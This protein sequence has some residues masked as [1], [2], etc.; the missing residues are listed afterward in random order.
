MRV[1]QVRFAVTAAGIV[2]DDN[3]RVLLLKHV[4]RPGSGWGLPGGFINPGEQPEVAVA[5]ELSEEVGLELES[6]QL[7]TT[8]VFKKPNQLEI[9]FRCRARGPAKPRSLEVSRIEWF[10]PEKLPDGL[11]MDQKR[12]IQHALAEGVVNSPAQFQ[13]NQ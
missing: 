10:A 9:V 5:R 1:T 8:R 2:T 13:S 4:F 7:F 3:G 6:V 12:L 11:P